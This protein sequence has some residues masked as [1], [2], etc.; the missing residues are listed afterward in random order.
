MSWKVTAFMA[1]AHIDSHI[2]LEVQDRNSAS[3][4]EA[5][6]QNA[7]N[8]VCA[9]KVQTTVAKKQRKTGGRE[10]SHTPASYD[11]DAL[12]RP[13]SGPRAWWGIADLVIEPNLQRFALTNNKDC[14]KLK[15]K[16][17]W[18]GRE[19]LLEPPGIK[20]QKKRIVISEAFLWPVRVIEELVQ[21][22]LLVGWC[23]VNAARYRHVGRRSQLSS[24]GFLRHNN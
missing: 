22:A 18:R 8:Q 21:D 2:Y 7:Q 10:R 1:G 19:A 9:L 17:I 6:Y 15:R 5:K 23:Y 13:K 11:D 24:H 4:T 12:A 20:L 14:S 16:E 3:E